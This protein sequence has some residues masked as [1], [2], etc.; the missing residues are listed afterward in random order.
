[1]VFLSHT[2]VFVNET[3]EATNNFSQEASSLVGF[4]TGRRHTGP[5][6][7]IINESNFDVN[8]IGYKINP[9]KGY[10]NYSIL[11]TNYF[12]DVPIKVLSKNIATL[13]I[14]C[15]LKESFSVDLLLSN[16]TYIT[17]QISGDPTTNSCASLYEIND[18]G[19]EYVLVM[20]FKD[21][22]GTLSNLRLNDGGDFTVVDWTSNGDF[23]EIN[24]SDQTESNVVPSNVKIF[25]KNGNMTYFRS[26][27]NGF[28]FDI[29]NLPKDLVYFQNTGNNQT[30]GDIKKLPA[31]L[32]YYR[33]AG[34]NI[35][36]GDVVNLP[37]G[38]TYY[39]NAGDNT[40]TGDIK[41]LPQDLTYYYNTGNNTTYGDIKN[42][43]TGLT[44]YLNTGNNETYGDIK[45]L[46]AE[47]FYFY[48]RNNY[49]A[50]TYTAGRSWA[51]NMQRIYY[52]PG[53]GL[54]LSIIEI[55]NL[56][57]DLSV[58]D[59]W[60]ANKDIYLLGSNPN[61]SDTSQGGIWGSYDSGYNPSDLAIAL[62]ILVKIKD[63]DVSLNNITFPDEFGD[64]S[65]FPINFGD[66]WRSE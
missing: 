2:N 40:T 16:N 42:L 49:Q 9:P 53:P 13:K 45:D 43:P 22:S 38:L 5:F 35:T 17:I 25:A 39:F 52:R 3:I 29:K 30:Y 62:K 19:E 18:V 21:N 37:D 56:L 33:N 34:N 27:N 8:I 54:G 41:N 10:I 63:V 15:V 1:M 66:W 11:N 23:Q 50:N 20:E 57:V 6:I 4:I 55:T 7:N 24:T 26:T 60:T 64:G 12:L 61:M 51:N 31:G 46:P 28:N 65:G 36:S 48:N 58:I 44:T 59:N 47:I 14:H 32:T